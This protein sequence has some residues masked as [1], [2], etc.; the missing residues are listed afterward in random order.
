MNQTQQHVLW[1]ARGSSSAL[2]SEIALHAASPCKRQR[3]RSRLSGLGFKRR[4]A[5]GGAAGAD[6]GV[7][8]GSH[9]AVAS[10]L[11]AVLSA[12]L[13]G[14]RLGYTRM[15]KLGLAVTRRLFSPWLLPRERGD[16]Q[17]NNKGR[18]VA[19]LRVAQGGAVWATRYLARRGCDAG[20][21]GVLPH[22]AH[23]TA[24]GW[25]LG[26][27]SLPASGKWVVGLGLATG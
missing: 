21:R 6:A 4:G 23:N 18:A 12:L 7:V 15:H 5:G 16:K 27:A 8:A 20:E 14:G 11:G 13:F 22:N 2:S 1:G 10:L 9:L 25:V 19:V 26:A 17:T 3:A 24:L